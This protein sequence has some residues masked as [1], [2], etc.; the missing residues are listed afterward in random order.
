M[1]GLW[2]LGR[3]AVLALEGRAHTVHGLVICY[4]ANYINSEGGQCS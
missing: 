2:D 4:Q 1:K 3:W